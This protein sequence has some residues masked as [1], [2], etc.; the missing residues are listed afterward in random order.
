MSESPYFDALQLEGLAIA[1]ACVTCGKCFEACPM[2]DPAGLKDHES[3]SVVKGVIDILRGGQGTEPARRWS[4]VC[5]N[6]GSCIPACE[7]GVN[8]R[9]MMSLAGLTVKTNA[10]AKAN[11]AKA[12]DVFHKMSR[13]VKI[14]SRLQLSPE[15]LARVNLG[16]HRDTTD[17]PPEI[18]FYTGCNVLKTPHIA[19]LCLDMMD[20][21][22]VN[23]EVMGGTSHCCG[24]YQYIAGDASGSGR[25]AFSTLEKLAAA[26]AERIL[27]WCPSCQIQLGEIALPAYARTEGR[28][29]IHISPFVEYLASRI[30]DLRPLMK[31]PVRKRVALHER[32]TFPGV[33][34]GVKK[35]LSS[36]AGLELVELDVLRAGSMSNSLSVLP[37][38]K[39]S[40]REQE[41]RAA[42]EANVT[43][44]ATVYHACHREICHYGE[45]L[46]FEIVNFM[47]ILG[48]SMGLSERD[49]YKRLK[50][51]KDVDTIL[52][53]TQSNIALYGL[54]NDTV[55]EAL[56][57]E[58]W[59]SQPL[60][61][62]DESAASDF[63]E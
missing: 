10:G 27:S 21:L 12:V 47:E 25:L 2:T 31:F 6:S 16:P 1:D 37:E 26:G 22:N 42:A 35:L 59:N 8:P 44:L 62:P 57:T 55:R 9:F 58:F 24:V 43:T 51:M 60:G 30:D 61:I 23:Y 4:A 19:L 56:Y 34:D 33:T 36:I 50:V 54:Q 38:F 3:T 52:E 15:E 20:A 46:D 11:R 5:T 17:V 28:C 48:E 7:Y 13:G 39:N 18:L 49:S 32:P 40:L 45:G 53:D 41:F 29:T 63:A 14:L